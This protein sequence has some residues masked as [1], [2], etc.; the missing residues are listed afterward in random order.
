MDPDPDDFDYEGEHIT[1]SDS[2]PSVG[3]GFVWMTTSV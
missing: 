3:N 2:I 1:W